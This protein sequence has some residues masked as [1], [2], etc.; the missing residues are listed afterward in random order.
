[1]IGLAAGVALCAAAYFLPP[2]KTARER[3]ARE[4]LLDE[5]HTVTLKNCTLK[6]YGGRHDGGYLMCE[7]LI[8]G[9]QSAYSYGIGKE[10]EWGCDVSRQFEVTVHQYDCFTPHRPICVGGQFVFHNECVGDRREL[11]DLRPFDT[12]TAQIARN[13]DERKRLLVKLDVEGAEWGSLIAAPDEVLD[14]IDQMPMEFH[15]TNEVRFAELI[16]RLKTKFYLVNLHFNNWACT[17]ETDPLPAFAFQVLWVNKRLGVVNPEGPSPAPMSP[18]NAPD[19]PN[20]PDC[21]LASSP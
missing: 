17:P 10:D 5:L 19:N 9:V 8:P 14:A 16:R 3:A 7:N 18:M 2:W 13:R 1:M 21:Q 6:R 11:V 20:A 4:A 12:I 15:G